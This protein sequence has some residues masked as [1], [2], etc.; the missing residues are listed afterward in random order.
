MILKETWRPKDACSKRLDTKALSSRTRAGVDRE[1]EAMDAAVKGEIRKGDV[2]VVRYEG[3][4]GGPGMREMLGL[5]AALVGS[6]LAKM[7]HC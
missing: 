4:R 5:T 7:S 6:D 3:P 1:E 2:V